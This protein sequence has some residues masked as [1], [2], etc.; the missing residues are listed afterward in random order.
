M[1]KCVKFWKLLESSPSCGQAEKEE[2]SKAQQ[3]FCPS[4]HLPHLIPQCSSDLSSLCRSQ[5]EGEVKLQGVE[6]WTQGEASV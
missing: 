3:P 6:G 1:G 2:G 5:E 4:P